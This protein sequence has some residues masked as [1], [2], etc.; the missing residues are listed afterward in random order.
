[1]EDV[2]WVISKKVQSMS[3]RQKLYFD[4]MG[5][6][7]SRRDIQTPSTPLYLLSKSK[8]K[9]GRAVSTAWWYWPAIFIPLALG[10]GII[11]FLLICIITAVKKR[12]LRREKSFEE[13]RKR[14]RSH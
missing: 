14:I 3:S 2:F 6:T 8:I 10:V 4:N 9:D 1:M 7:S 11:T 5:T 13:I 12:K